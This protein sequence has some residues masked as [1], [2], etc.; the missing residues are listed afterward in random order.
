MIKSTQTFIEVS[1]ADSLVGDKMPA[2]VPLMW[3]ELPNPGYSNSYAIMLDRE[4][5]EVWNN[6]IMFEFGDK[7]GYHFDG[8]ILVGNNPAM[9]EDADWLL[10]ERILLAEWGIQDASTIEPVTIALEKDGSE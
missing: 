9:I 1:A 10:E 8:D 7:A 5:F 3:E 4:Q 2:F 6:A